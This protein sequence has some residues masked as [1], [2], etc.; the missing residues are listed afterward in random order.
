MKQLLRKWFLN[1][2]TKK[3]GIILCLFFYYYN[4]VSQVNYVP[5]PS[6]ED[7]ISLAT[8]ET[9]YAPLAIKN[10][11]N[12]D[13]NRIQNCIFSY[14]HVN[15]FDQSLGVPFNNYLYYCPA[16]SGFGYAE[17]TTYFIYPFSPPPVTLRSVARVR[18][19]N[20]L[21]SGKKYCAKSYVAPF[22]AE[23]WLTNGYGMYFDNG[24]L[25]TIVAMDSS[26]IYPFVTP[27]VKAQQIISD[28]ANWT[29]VSG[30]F[31]ANGT[32]AFCTLGNF[33]SDSNTQKI[34]NPACNGS[35]CN[36]SEV[37]I[38]DVSV[39]PVDIANWLP[40]VYTTL[41]DSVYIGLPTYEVP[42]AV[43]YTINGVQIAKG[44]GI[45][46]KAIQ[47]ITQ[48]IQA[49]DVCDRIAYDT[50]TVYAYPTLNSSLSTNNYQ[51]SIIPN[52]A[53]EIFVVEKVLGTKVQLVN[54][55]GQIVQEQKVV[56][57]NAVFNVGALARGVYYVKG[58]RQVGKVVLE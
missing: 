56:N 10:W 7:T 22:D 21:L 17:I 36:C 58:E 54:M 39:I 48:Y 16:H 5:N 4:G 18:L 20:K 2:I 19:K 29:L 38:D 14:F 51:L 34:N 47:P 11:K 33:L 8:A 32:E 45:T 27:Q 12:L 37:A 13:S 49:I 3:A 1:N 28:T 46:I 42:D 35:L 52:P 30:T 6:F 57:N 41:G 23:Q 53:K 24:Q 25:D 26:G 40:N 55:Y 15:A 50:V 9:Q 43:W 31:V 44:S